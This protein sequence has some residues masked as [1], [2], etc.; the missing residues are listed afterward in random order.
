MLLILELEGRVESYPG[1]LFIR[2]RS[3]A[4]Q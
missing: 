1:G 2:T 4:V 3:E